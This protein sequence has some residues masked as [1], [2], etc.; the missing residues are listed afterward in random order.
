MR[1]WP[2]PMENVRSTHEAS[3]TRCCASKKRTYDR[4]H[5]LVP[6]TVYN[7]RCFCLWCRDGLLGHLRSTAPLPSRPHPAQGR[8]GISSRADKRRLEAAISF[9]AATRLNSISRRDLKDNPIIPVAARVCGAVK[10][11]SGIEHQTAHRICPVVAAGE[12]VECGGRPAAVPMGQLKNRPLSNP[13]AAVGCGAVEVAGC[14][15]DQLGFGV[16]SPRTAGEAVNRVEEP[17]AADRRKLEHCAAPATA[18]K[19]GRSVEIAGGGIQYHPRLGNASIVSAAKVKDGQ[20]CPARSGRRQ[21]VNQAPIEWAAG[22]EL[23]VKIARS[24]KD[25]AIYR[26]CPV[27]TFLGCIE[28]GLDPAAP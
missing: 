17:T 23:A 6:A 1:G 24:V 25:N 14:I 21:L 16:A 7:R 26:L 18:A 5:A 4:I 15:P 22:L 3:R 27:A 11:T 10:V 9:A 28:Y 2:P 8:Q 13:V 12:S 19:I 20:F